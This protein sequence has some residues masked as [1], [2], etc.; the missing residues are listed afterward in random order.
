MKWVIIK[1]FEQVN[2]D[3]HIWP[4]FSLFPST[5]AKTLLPYKYHMTSQLTLLRRCKCVDDFFSYAFCCVESKGLK[6]SLFL[7]SFGKILH[8]LW[9]RE[10]QNYGY[11]SCFMALI[12]T[13]T[14]FLLLFEGKEGKGN[15]REGET[16]SSSREFHI[17]DE[18]AE[19]TILDWVLQSLCVW[20][21]R[22]FNVSSAILSS[23][24]T[25]LLQESQVEWS[26]GCTLVLP[27]PP[28]VYSLTSFLQPVLDMMA[29]VQCWLFHNCLNITC[30]WCSFII[31]F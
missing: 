26:S 14:L 2:L 21:V 6:A 28:G 22:I 25:H 19:D 1:P 30:I 8:V 4:S 11:C 13:Y 18:A 27:P 17:T 31:R 16:F 5:A 24:I 7:V 12:P 10:L 9:W 15:E 20:C 3:L 29:C 23:Y